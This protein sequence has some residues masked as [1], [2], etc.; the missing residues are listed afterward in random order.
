VRRDKDI[1]LIVE[2]P[3]CGRRIVELRAT[4]D[5]AH[6]IEAILECLDLACDQC[7]FDCSEPRIR[8][9]EIN[10]RVK[11]GEVKE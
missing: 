11:V 9:S 10:A 2:C 5:G 4:R 7:E 6:D 1:E 3:R 8:N